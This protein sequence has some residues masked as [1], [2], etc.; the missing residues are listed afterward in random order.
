M[1]PSFLLHQLLQ[2]HGSS[3]STEGDHDA[4]DPAAE[5]IFQTEY[6]FD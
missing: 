1:T 2:L 4:S 3:E 6:F 5:G